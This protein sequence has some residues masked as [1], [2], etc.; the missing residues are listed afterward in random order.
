MAKSRT[1]RMPVPESKFTA[2]RLLAFTKDLQT[3]RVPLERQQIS[4]DMQLGL[5]A[6]CHKSGLIAFHVSYN[7]GDKRPFMRLGTFD[8][9]KDPDYITIEDARELAKTVRA[10]GD[11]GIDVQEGLHRRLIRELKEKGT[12][13]RAPK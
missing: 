11:K 7:V 10:L 12:N 13:W 4:D 3:Q 6:V 5:R 8:N 2:E 1:K 9:P